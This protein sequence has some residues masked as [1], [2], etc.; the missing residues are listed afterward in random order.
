MEDVKQVDMYSAVFELHR[1]LREA[2]WYTPDEASGDRITALADACFVILTELN[3]EDIK[4]RTEEFQR[5]T[6]V[7]E[8]T[9]EQLKKLEK[10]IESMVH[11]IATVTALIQSI[12]SVLKLSG[13]FFKL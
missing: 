7:M 8:K 12:D 5:L 9:N 1:L 6:R 4:S 10:E 11:S 13:L 2:Y 3:L